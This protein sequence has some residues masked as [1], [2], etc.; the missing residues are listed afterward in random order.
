MSWHGTAIA[1]MAA[2]N[3][4]IPGHPDMDGTEETGEQVRMRR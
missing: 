3:E 4:G 1:A 2:L